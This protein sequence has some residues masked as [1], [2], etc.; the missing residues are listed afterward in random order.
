MPNW[1]Q[2]TLQ[3]E[4]CTPINELLEE[5]ALRSGSR[6]RESGNEISAE[7][8]NR[9][10]SYRTALLNELAAISHAIRNWEKA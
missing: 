5:A 7:L 2:K 6:T 4:E 9:E 1:N 10:E 8:Y 3:Y